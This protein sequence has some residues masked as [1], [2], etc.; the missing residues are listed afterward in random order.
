MQTLFRKVAFEDVERLVSWCRDHDLGRGGVFEV[1]DDPA[2]I[3]RIMIVV[4]FL[5]PKANVGMLQ[6]LGTFYCNYVEPG[7][8][9]LDEDQEHDGMPSRLEDIERIKQIIDCLLREARPGV[10]IDLSS[11]YR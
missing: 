11:T 6:P 1:Y 2:G 5:T 8:I 3:N 9:S 4:N 7:V 10:E